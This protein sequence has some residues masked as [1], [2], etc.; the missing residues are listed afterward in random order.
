MTW[1][2]NFNK[3]GYDLEEHYFAKIN[4]ELI[5]KLKQ[6]RLEEGEHPELKAEDSGSGAK[7]LAFPQR[8]KEEE[9][10][11]EKKAA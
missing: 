5:E 9:R 3:I 4:Q 1:K 7:I 11:K 10:K 6:K 2:N 8:G